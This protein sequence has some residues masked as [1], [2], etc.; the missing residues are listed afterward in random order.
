[1]QIQI[2]RISTYTRRTKKDPRR[3]GARATQRSRLHLNG[4]SQQLVGFP[5]PPRGHHSL[6]RHGVVNRRGAELGAISHAPQVRQRPTGV[7]RQRTRL[8]RHGV[9]TRKNLQGGTRNGGRGG[10]KGVGVG[11]M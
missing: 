1:M 9:A 11:S 8:Q 5:R 6:H 7:A 2:P 4:L 3:N 10:K